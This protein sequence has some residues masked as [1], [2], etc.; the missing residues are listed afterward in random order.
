M[1]MPVSI[2]VRD[3]VPSRRLR[4]AF[5]WLR[6]VDTRFSTYRPESEVAR[7]DRGALAI[8]DADSSVRAVL[9]RCELLRQS[10]GGFFDVR[11]TGRL[12]PSGFVKGWAIDRTAELLEA[13]GARRFCI[14][15]GGDI[16]VRGSEPW[17]IGIRHPL[18]H[19]RLAGVVALSDGALATSGAYERGHHVVDPRSC[20]PPS[21]VL[22]VTVI[23]PEL[24]AADAYATA[25]FAMGDRGPAWTASLDGHDAM[26][27]LEP[28]RVLS[29]TGFVA[30]CPGGSVTASLAL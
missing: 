10:T 4:D 5:E 15:A 23:G 21:G 9:T 7:L 26:T 3:P 24:G 30:R 28:D 19:D 2:D 22:S 11:A 25:A 14:N 12:D 29:T 6:L 13:A 8:E 18:R 27:I 16:L 20:R 17:R 1:G